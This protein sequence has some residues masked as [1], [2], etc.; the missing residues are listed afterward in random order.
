MSY[1]HH[2]AIGLLST[3]VLF[4]AAGACTG[5]VGSLIDPNKGN[6][7]SGASGAGNGEGGLSLGTGAGNGQGGDMDS[8]ADLSV[9]PQAIPVSMY[10]TVDKSGSMSDNNKWNNA[11]QAFEAFFTSPDA[12]ALNVALRFWPDQGCDT[13]CN[14]GPC[15][16][17][18]VPMG[19]LSD[20]A[21]EQALIDAFNSKSPGG[22]TPMEAALAGAEQYALDW[23]ATAE[24][25]GRIVVILLTD[26]IPTACDQNINNIASYA[27]DAFAQSEI[28]TFAV[29]L[30]GSNESQ[31][32]TIAMAGNTGM[33]Y[34]IGN[35]NTQQDLLNA[36]IDI[37]KVA[38]SCTF[39]MPES[40]DPNQVI[41]P[42]KV[43]VE[44]T[45][46][47][48]S[49][50]VEVPRV[51]GESACGAAGG[52]YYDDNENPSIITLCPATCDAAN[53]S[54]ESKVTIQLGCATFIP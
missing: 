19:S 44:L 14:V 1:H 7:G 41:D 43:V 54:D 35:G 33:G 32:N 10:I 53:A 4:A 30:Q 28:L 51:T 31:M 38:V 22:L 37:Q 5:D 34:F 40:P 12:D 24:A 8:C 3:S 20:P 45:P 29:G 39:A 49:T 15:A 16:Q 50:P 26:G 9:E 2:L 42:E 21:H 48:T 6:S 36:L 47:G 13:S 25:G 11:R 18:Q 27:A 23:Q 17:P 46:D 52:W